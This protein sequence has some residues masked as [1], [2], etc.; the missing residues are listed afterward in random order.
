MEMLKAFISEEDGSMTAE[1]NSAVCFGGMAILVTSI[2]FAYS[3]RLAHVFASVTNV[4]PK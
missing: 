1:F 2:L 4:I 3:S